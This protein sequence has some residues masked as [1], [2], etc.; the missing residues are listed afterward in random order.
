MGLTHGGRFPL[1]SPRCENSRKM[2]IVSGSIDTGL[3]RE[4]RDLCLNVLCK[5][6]HIQFFLPSLVNTKERFLF[7]Q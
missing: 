1:Y 5:M 6:A 7:Q 2:E 4:G 3:E